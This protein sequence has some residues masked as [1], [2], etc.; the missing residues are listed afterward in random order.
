M[1]DRYRKPRS[2]N[3]VK[4]KGIPVPY[5]FWPDSYVTNQGRLMTSNPWACMAAHINM[6][7]KSSRQR[8]RALAF[9]EQAEDFYLAAAAPRLRSRPLL[10]YYSYLNLAKAFLVVRKNLE[11][12][13][14]IHGVKEDGENIRKR[15]TITSQKVKVNDQKGKRTQIYREFVNECG[16]AVPRK[17]QPSRLVDLLEQVIGVEQILSQTLNRKRRFIPVDS[18]TLEFNPDSKEVWVTIMVKREDLA[19]SSDIPKEIR[20]NNTSLEEVESPESLYKRYESK[21]V[22]RYKKSPKDALRDLVKETKKDLWSLLRPGG[23]RFY[24]SSIPAKARLAQVASCFQAMFYFG[25]VARYR[26]DDFVKLAEGKHGWLVREFINT[27]A[28]QFVYL[29]GSGLIGAEMIIPEA[30]I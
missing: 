27:Q 2:G 5:T 6:K 17:P 3:Q 26:P 13:K 23:Y 8:Q 29:L 30:A 25:S 7:M 10:Y 18:A 16:F 20:H 19:I 22:K 28:L 12:F 1:A 9:L 24:L 21:D 15:L 11:L 4:V 14:C